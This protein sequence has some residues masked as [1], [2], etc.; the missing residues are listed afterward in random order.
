MLQLGDTVKKGVVSEMKPIEEL[1]ATAHLC[2]S[3]TTNYVGITLY[4]G[5]VEWPGF[6]GT[7]MFGYNEGQDKNMEHVS[8]SSFKKKQLPTWDDMCKL[9]DMF[10][11]PH[12][13][14][15]QIHPS[16]DRYV[17]S[18]GVGKNTRENVLHLW[19]PADGDFSILNSPER[20]D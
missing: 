11:Y 2:I 9:K 20:W 17:H 8:I 15:V 3:G 13:M 19:R 18:V 1:R 4:N 5:W 6:K 16:E 7:V 14:V 12:E 10:F